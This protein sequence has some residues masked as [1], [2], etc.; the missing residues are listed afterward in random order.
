MERPPHEDD[1][2]VEPGSVRQ[3]IDWSA[4]DALR[5]LCAGPFDSRETIARDHALPATPRPRRGRR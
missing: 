2:D 4:N 5:S 3:L 1:E